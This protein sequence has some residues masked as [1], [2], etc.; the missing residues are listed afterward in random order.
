M[1][2]LIGIRK[3]YMYMYMYVAIYSREI[4]T[5]EFTGFVTPEYSSIT[6]YVG[7]N[8]VLAVWLKM[9]EIVFHNV[10]V[11]CLFA[12]ACFRLTLTRRTT[13]ICECLVRR[14]GHV[15]VA[16]NKVLEQHLLSNLSLC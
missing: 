2:P 12:L 10:N 4:Y 7:K 5:R 13:V 9:A 8:Y 15:S 16:L 1:V 14:E 6:C 11:Y 3:I